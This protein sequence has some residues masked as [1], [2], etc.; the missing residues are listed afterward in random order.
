MAAK[1][2]SKMKRTPGGSPI[3]DVPIRTNASGP[4]GSFY[5]KRPTAQV[6]GKNGITYMVPIDPE[7]GRVP[8]DVLYEHFLDYTSW[9]NS[10]KERS[11]RIDS[12]T[13]AKKIHVPKDE[14]G[15]TPEEIVESGWWA[16]VN[17]SDVMG[18]DDGTSS[19]LRD[20][21]DVKSSA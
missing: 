3:I 17:G 20:W 19:S 4:D 6:Q 21:K 13:A 16:A 1:K 15:F 8:E 7:T 10:G 12:R 2:K 11:P 18:V 5:R 14:N 9:S